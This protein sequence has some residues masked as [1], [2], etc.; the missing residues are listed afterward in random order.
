[1]KTS[2]YRELY[3]DIV[4]RAWEDVNFKNELLSKP[5]ETVE[6]INKC[7]LNFEDKQDLLENT[8]IWKVI[9]LDN[10]II[11]VLIYK[12]KYGLKMVAC[13]INETYKNIAKKD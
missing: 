7:G 12:A 5:L 3:K 11:G 8:S 1:M 13:A 2:E 10:N 9:Y 6:K 4:T